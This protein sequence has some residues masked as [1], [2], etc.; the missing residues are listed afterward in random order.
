M[1]HSVFVLL[2][3]CVCVVAVFKLVLIEFIEVSEPSFWGKCQH[4]FVFL[5]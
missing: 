1:D 2:V 3:F 4:L 5:K